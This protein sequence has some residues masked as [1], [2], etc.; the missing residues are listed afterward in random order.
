MMLADEHGAS[1]GQTVAES[2]DAP[3]PGPLR[4]APCSLTQ[5]PHFTDEELGLDTVH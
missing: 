2:R 4:K 1:P 3:A 5:Q